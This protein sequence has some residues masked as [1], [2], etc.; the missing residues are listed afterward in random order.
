MGELKSTREYRV[1]A[2]E[3]EK[4][5][6]EQVDDQQE[7]VEDKEV[8]AKVAGELN[9]VG[10]REASRAVKENVEKA[11]KSIDAKM[12][13]QAAEHQDMAHEAHDEEQDIE[14][15]S[16]ASGQ[17][18]Q[19]AERL[20]R[21][22]NTDQAQQQMRAAKR[23]AQQAQAFLSDVKQNRERTREQSERQ[24]KKQLN[25]VKSTTVNV[26]GG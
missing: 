9:Q 6:Y 26:S 24:T 19:K 2:S 13:G 4:E 20:A 3:Q 25:K 18:A 7:T 8:T 21:D 11:G 15:R 1:E 22:V 17:D 14:H 16:D 23:A 5:F 10:T 12:D